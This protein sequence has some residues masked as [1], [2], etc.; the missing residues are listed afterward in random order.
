MSIESQPQNIN[1]MG[2]NHALMVTGILMTCVIVMV[3]VT[4]LCMYNQKVNTY[5]KKIIYRSHKNSHIYDEIKD[6]NRNSNNLVENGNVEKYTANTQNIE[7]ES[8]PPTLELELE[9]QR[10]P[11]DLHNTKPNIY[12]DK[13]EKHTTREIDTNTDTNGSN[14]EKGKK[15]ND[16][17]KWNTNQRQGNHTTIEC[18]NTAE[19]NNKLVER[20]KTNGK[21]RLRIPG[22]EN[23]DHVD[24][25]NKK[26]IL[27]YLQVNFHLIN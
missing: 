11:M 26:G 25:G 19:E 24:H 22:M 7:A 18:E 13:T 8:T 20:N 3:I 6:T 14:T 9:T 2:S 17:D 1:S 23:C 5:L 16:I 10:N 12:K 15:L 27:I 21:R 4:M